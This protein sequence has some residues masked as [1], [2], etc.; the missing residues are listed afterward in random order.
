MTAEKRAKL[1]ARLH[2]AAIHLLRSVRVADQETGLTP[3]RLSALSVLVF[4]GACTVGELAAAE[5]VT[6]PTMTRLVSG[7]EQAGL[8]TRSA[9]PGDGRVVRVAATAAAGEML[10]AARARR[11]ALLERK[12]RGLSD[13]EWAALEVTLAALER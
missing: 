4:G 7:L 5:Q 11:L 2:R 13:A 9:D 6:A 8:V 10:E 12:L 3:A 1:A